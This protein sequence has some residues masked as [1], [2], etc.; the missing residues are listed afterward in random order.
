MMKWWMTTTLTF[1][2]CV[3]YVSTWFAL[4]VG[5]CNC[6]LLQRYNMPS[7]DIGFPTI[8]KQNFIYLLYTPCNIPTK[9]HLKMI[10]FGTCFLFL[11][12]PCLESWNPLKLYLDDITIFL[13]NF[14]CVKEDWMYINVNP[15]FIWEFHAKIL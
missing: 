10:C 13:W 3:I 14:V 11:F 8:S 12:F 6:I 7:L 5:V 15:F 1:H 9:C 2:E 4:Y